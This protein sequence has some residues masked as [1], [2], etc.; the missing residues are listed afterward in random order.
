MTRDTKP[1]EPRRPGPFRGPFSPLWFGA[2]LFGLLLIANALSATL[3][4]AETLGT[5]LSQILKVQSSMLRMNRSVRAEKLSAS[6]SLRILIPSMLILMAVVLVV[7]SPFIIR[8][9][10]SGTWW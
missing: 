9:W 2:V 5:P 3:N 4:Q 7:F 10:H 8:R 1:K 6:A